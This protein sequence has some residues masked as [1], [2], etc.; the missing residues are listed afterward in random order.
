M[1]NIL[2]V[3][4]NWLGD[5]IFSSPVFKAIKENYPQAHVACLA[6][7]RVKEVLESIPG[8]D[9]IIIYDEK[10]AH[11]TPWAKWKLITELR[12]RQFDIAFLLRGSL[13]RAL[14]V[15]LAKIPKRVGYPTKGRAWFLTH[16]VKELP[17]EVHRCDYYLNVIEDF[18]KVKDRS[19]VLEVSAEAQEEVNQFFRA[20]ELD[21]NEPFL[22]I[23]VGGNWDLKRWAKKNFKQ[24]GKPPWED[25]PNLRIV[26]PGGA[27]DSQ[28]AEFVAGPAQRELRPVI[29]TGETNLKELIALMKKAKLV[30]SADSGPLH[31]ANAVG[32]PTVGLFGPT[33]PEITGP[34]GKG[35]TT[36]LHKEIGCNQA[37]CYYLE[38]PD[39]MCMKAITV[40]EVVGVIK[41]I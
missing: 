30:V 24:F 9:E 3:N 32:T 37:P 40:D 38:C 8:I 36:L 22:I 2:V 6:V 31:I 10:G 41:Q 16:Q 35:R 28:L 34:R 25:H 26:L 5:V 33:R 14:L 12:L 27:Q 18:I 23:N 4:V 15:F 7:P 21:P 11:R 29:L 17:N 1:Q 20:R 39:N 19:C 13:T